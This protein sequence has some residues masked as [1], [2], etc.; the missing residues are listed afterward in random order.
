MGQRRVIFGVSDLQIPFEHQDAFDFV[1]HVVKTF[2][3]SG[4]NTTYVNLGDEVDQHTL[5]LK[6]IGDVNGLSAGEEIEIARERLKP[7]FKAYPKTSV[8]ISN[9]TWRGFKKAQSVGIP[10]QF[11][12][13]IADVYGAPPGWQWRDR[14]VYEGIL[15]EHG[16][17]VSGPTAALNAATQNR[18]CTVIG[19]Q[20]SNAG[21]IHSGTFQNTI[22]GL[23][24]GC[25]I[26]VD[27]YAF[28]YGKVYR[29]KP[30][31]GMAVVINRVPLFIPMVLNHKK[32]WVRRTV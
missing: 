26:D 11:L 28:S 9:H 2:S 6:H 27:K 18:L 8:C 10:Q 23:N 1:A 24:S 32:R 19:H 14:W 29:K 20:H 17:A 16:E 3:K 31:L 15:F 5:S 25:L 7:W 13:N 12:K 21:V 4:D 30:T 22:W